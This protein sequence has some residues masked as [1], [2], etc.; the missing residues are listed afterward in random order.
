VITTPNLAAWYNRIVLLFGF[1]PFWTDASLRYA[2]VG[3]LKSF[4]SGD[5]GH[6]RVFTYRALKNFLELHNFTIVKSTGA[7]YP[8]PHI[9]PFPSYLLEMIANHFPSLSSNPV[10][11]V[12]KMKHF[13]SPRSSL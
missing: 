13:K 7:S 4:G 3:K 11:I 1:Q 2:N 6:I 9:F 10:F 8:K 5:G 12:K